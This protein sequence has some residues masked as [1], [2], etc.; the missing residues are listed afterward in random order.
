MSYPPSEETPLKKRPNPL[1]RP[2]VPKGRFQHFA[3]HAAILPLPPTLPDHHPR[4]GE[5]LPVMAEQRHADPRP[6]RDV[7]AAKFLLAAQHLDEPKARGI[8]QGGEDTGAGF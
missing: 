7:G 6:L 5:H 1:M 2:N 3:V 8:A 4:V